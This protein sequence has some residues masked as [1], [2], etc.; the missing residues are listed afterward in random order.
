MDIQFAKTTNA[1]IIHNLMIQAFTEYKDETPPSSAL[2]ETVQSVSQALENG[3]Q[4]IIGY[5]DHQPAG[6]VRFKYQNNG[7]YFFRLS[8]IPEKQ[9]LGIAKKLLRYLEAVAIEKG[10]KELYCN[11]RLALPKNI[12]LYRSIGYTIYAEEVIHRP[13][14]ASVKIV[15]MVKRL[16]GIEEKGMTTK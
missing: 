7:L 13:N 6:M 14:G 11:V 9:G 12:T 10:I 8:V 4:G 1:P 16:E 5:I 2:V 3:E 15:K